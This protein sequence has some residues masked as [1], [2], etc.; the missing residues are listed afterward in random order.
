MSPFIFMQI[1]KFIE[2]LEYKLQEPLPG[3][4][5]QLKMAH[6]T[7]RFYVSAPNNA[8]RAG[9]LATLFPKNG[10]LNLVLIERNTNDNDRHGGQISFPGGKF[11]ETDQ[12]LLH[13]ALRET[14]EEIGIDRKDIRILGNLTDLYIPVSNFQVYPFVGFLNYEPIYKPQTEEVNAVL[15]VPV[16]HFKAPGI[17]NTT[18]IPVSKNLNLNNVPYFDVDGKILWGATAMILSELMEVID[19]N[20]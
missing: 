8:R 13:T 14:E 1:D 11:E 18:T 9:V 12:T 6:V 2:Q 15:E 19:R 17:I 20:W 7:R 16:R 5:A 10:E 4:E 3:R